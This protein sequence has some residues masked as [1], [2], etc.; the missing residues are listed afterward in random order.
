MMWPSAAAWAPEEAEITEAFDGLRAED[1]IR[2][3]LILVAA[4]VLGRIVQRV[5]TRVVRGDEATAVAARFIG[6]GV[7]V[8]VVLAGLVY[9]LNSLNVRLGP[10]LGALGIGGL[11]LAFGAQSILE[12]FFSS[13]LLQAR[14]PFRAGEQVSVGDGIEGVV[15]DINFRVVIIRTFDG[16]RVFVPASTVL[17][18]P[19]VNVTVRGPW[20]TSLTVGVAYGTDLRYAQ[21]VILTAVSGVTGALQTPAPEAWIERFGDS[22]IDFAIRFWHVPEMA[23][24]WEVRSDVAM[25]VAEKLEQSG[26]TIPFPQRTLWFGGTEE[27]GPPAP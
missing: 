17:Q 21:Q 18:N 22:S 14:H 7:G 23:V 15:E 26:I 13:I 10:L 19:I 8:L 16:E 20:R 9:A 5:A 25:A 6:R 27:N 24:R 4:I 1:W 12:N 2:A 11:A 3:A